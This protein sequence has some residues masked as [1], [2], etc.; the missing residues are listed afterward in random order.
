MCD[1]MGPKL[2]LLFKCDF[3]TRRYA[4]GIQC[5]LYPEYVISRVCYIPSMLYPEYVISRV[6][7]IQSML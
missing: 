3:Y 1:L 7:Y 4:Y 2:R 5:M 6:G